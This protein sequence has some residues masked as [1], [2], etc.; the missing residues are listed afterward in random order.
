MITKECG[1]ARP[2]LANIAAKT[3]ESGLKER[4]K[5]RLGKIKNGSAQ[6]KNERGWLGERNC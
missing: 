6:T 2:R 3:R 5:T 1:Y 4:K